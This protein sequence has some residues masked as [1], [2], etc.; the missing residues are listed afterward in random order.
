MD[1]AGLLDRLI[2]RQPQLTTSGRKLADAIL[3]N[4]GAAAQSSILELAQR[5][6]TS[7]AS[8]NRL[9]RQLG[10]RGYPELR[11]GLAR[12][13]G[14][15][16]AGDP[17]TD[18]TDDLAPDLGVRETLAILAGS[19]INAVQRTAALVDPVVVDAVATAI[20]SARRVQIAAQGGSAHIASYLAA[21]LTGIG[22]WTAATVDVTYT[23]A[24]AV[25][26]GSDD[27]ALAISHS[28]IAGPVLDFVEI[29]RE[30]GACT[31]AITSSAN[32]PL[33]LAADLSLSTT[34]RSASLRYRGTAGRHAQLYVCDAIYVR[35]AQRR[36]DEAERFLNLAGQVTQRYLAP[37]THTPRPSS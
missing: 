32:T 16:Q 29:A 5:A 14:A 24:Q 9:C 8:V 35:V 13:I 30:R 26:L 33:A 27:V 18:L 21:E 19:S 23:A 28:G 37:P 4:P 10:L 3:A 22:I 20:D 17:D 7:T 34:A 1:E 15:Q 11:L 31:V 2:E 6:G 12:A 25:T 36:A